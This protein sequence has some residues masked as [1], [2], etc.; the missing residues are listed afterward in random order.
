LQDHGVQAFVNVLILSGS[1]PPF[2]VLQVD[3]R[4]P[5]AFQPSDIAFLRTYA[6]LLGA[7]IDRCRVVAQLRQAL[8]DKEWLINELTIE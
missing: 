4:S 5:R 7:A 6:N 8:Q 3:S 1:G 2:G